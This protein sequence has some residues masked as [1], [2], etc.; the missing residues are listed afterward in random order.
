MTSA[1]PGDVIYG[2]RALNA[3]EPWIVPQAL[4][5][6]KELVQPDWRVFEWGAG[7]STLWFGINCAEIWS[8]EQGMKWR[9]WVNNRVDRYDVTRKVHVMYVPTAEAFIGTGDSQ[10]RYEDVILDWP[11]AHWDMVYVDGE[12]TLRGPCILN[13][14]ACLKPGGWLLLD[15]SNWYNGMWLKGWHREHYVAPP[16]KW[17]DRP[18]EWWTSFFRK[19]DTKHDTGELNKT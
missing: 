13:T 4:L 17:M 3:P 2:R 18:N 15:N 1:I 10:R 12:A 9:D 11:E 8:V 19:P 6:L 5:R 14:V 7:G 16:H